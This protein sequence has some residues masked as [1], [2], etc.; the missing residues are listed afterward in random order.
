MIRTLSTARL[1]ELKGTTCTTDYGHTK[2]K[3]QILCGPN[4]NPNLGVGYKGLVFCRNNGWIMENMDKELTVPKWV[5][6]IWPKISQMPQ[7]I[8]AQNVPQAQ[9]FKI[10]EK[11]SL[12]VS[13]VR[14]I[15]GPSEGLK[16]RGCQYNLLG[17][18]C[19]PWLR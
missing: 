10:L 3:S 4:S 1:V 16:I 13:V 5:L 14:D 18:I 2:A 19:P 9:K 12:W 7:K 6:I 8:S 15:S 17:I 11:S